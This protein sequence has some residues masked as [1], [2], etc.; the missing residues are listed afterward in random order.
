M[1][2]RGTLLYQLLGEKLRRARERVGM[3]QSKL[4]A[5]VGLSRTS[6]VNIESGRQHA[7][8]HVLGSLAQELNIELASLIPRS[9]EL[10]R[11]APALELD[12]ATV[13]HI[14]K[15]VEGDASAKRHLEEFIKRARTAKE[16]G[17]DEDTP[18]LNRE[19]GR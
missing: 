7:P 13:R 3:S 5:K 11:C 6:L 10:G 8:L 9:D 19:K 14:E 17:D 2:R 4:S 1:E 18:I 15:D 12:A 16:A